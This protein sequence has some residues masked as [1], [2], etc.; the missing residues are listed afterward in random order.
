MPIT[1][2]RVDTTPVNSLTRKVVLGRSDRAY[3]YLRA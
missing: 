3:R 1:V 2:K